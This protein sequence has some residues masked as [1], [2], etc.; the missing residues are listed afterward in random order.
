MYLFNKSKLF[1]TNFSTK[2]ISKSKRFHPTKQSDQLIYNYTIVCNITNKLTKIP[3]LC[4]LCF[5]SIY[6]YLKAI[7]A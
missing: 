2:F 7:N 5:S 4:S 6:G 3:V 1:E